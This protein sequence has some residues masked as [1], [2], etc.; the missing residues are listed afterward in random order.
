MNQRDAHGERAFLLDESIIALLSQ[1]WR[2]E[3]PIS[4][5]LSSSRRV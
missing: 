4:K 5:A 1:L 3:R 2:Y